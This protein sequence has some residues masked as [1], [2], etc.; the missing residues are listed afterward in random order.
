MPGVPVSEKIAGETVYVT[1]KQMNGLLW[2]IIGAITG[3]CVALLSAGWSGQAGVSDK[4]AKQSEEIGAI[5][6]DVA[7]IKVRV[8][9]LDRTA[10][11]E[12]HDVNQAQYLFVEVPAEITAR[13][14]TIRQL[15]REILTRQG[16]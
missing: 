12:T 15:S 5:R 6:Q 4:F 10:V 8:E 9:S 7:V 11:H 13:E 16:K 14:E 2:K 3:A 1:H